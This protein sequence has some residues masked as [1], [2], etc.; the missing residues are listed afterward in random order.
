L[1]V[2]YTPVATPHLGYT[3]AGEVPLDPAARKL[4]LES[5]AAGASDA[6]IAASLGLAAEHVREVLPEPTWAEAAAAASRLQKRDGAYARTA[7]EVSAEI[8]RMR[9]E[10]ATDDA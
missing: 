3:P 8:A 1:A 6:Q 4:I 9:L 5:A 10:Q 7:H 2:G